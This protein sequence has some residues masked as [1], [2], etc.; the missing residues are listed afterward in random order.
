MARDDWRLRIELTNEHGGGL[1]QR[2]GRWDNDARELAHDLKDMRLAVTRDDDTVFVYAGSSLELEKARTLIDAELKELDATPLAIVVEHWLA[3]EGRWDDDASAADV[4]GDVLAEGYAPWEV[5]VELE[6]HDEARRLAEQLEGEGYGVV[7]RWN[8]VIAGCATREQ[9][10][11]LAA[12][13]HGR[14]EAGGEVIWEAAPFNP[15]A[16][17]GGIGDAGGP[18]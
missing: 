3:D 11:E 6:H 12:R 14:V 13:V 17:F 10:E 18:I 9:A 1:L 7:R 2:L 16:V 4:D 8:F 5:R 15:F